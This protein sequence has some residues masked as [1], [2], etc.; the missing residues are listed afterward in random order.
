MQFDFPL[1]VNMLMGKMLRCRP[2]LAVIESCL[3]CHLT[4]AAAARSSFDTN[5]I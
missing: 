1:L 3:K 5:L 4:M 2:V